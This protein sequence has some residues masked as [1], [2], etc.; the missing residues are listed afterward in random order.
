MSLIIVVIGGCPRSLRHFVIVVVCA[1]S[2]PPSL[3][4]F[5]VLPARPRPQNLTVIVFVRTEQLRREKAG[6][7]TISPAEAS[8]L[9]RTGKHEHGYA[10]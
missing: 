10:R 2:R 3:N 5:A 9:G 4:R 6:F 7:D 8:R 1:P